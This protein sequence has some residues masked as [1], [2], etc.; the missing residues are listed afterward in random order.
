MHKNFW[1]V[2]FFFSANFIFSQNQIKDFTEK[3][4]LPNQVKE[5]SGLLFFN[6]KIITHNDS[7]DNSNLYELDSLTGN[8][9]R[10]V[11][12]TNATNIDWEDIAQDENHIYIGDF[13]NNNGN[14]INL[15]IYKILKSDFS[16]NTTV[17]AEKISFAYEDQTNFNN[18][19]NSHNFDAEALIVYNNQL[20]IFTKNRLDYRTNVYKLPTEPG[21]YAA[22]KVSTANVS[23]LITG[24]TTQNNHIMLCG[25]NSVGRPFLVYIN[26]QEKINDDIFF[27][28]FDKYVLTTE[29]EQGSQVEGITAYDDGKF[30]ISRE[31][32][33]IGSLK[34]PQK[35]YSF[36][37]DR[38]KIL[39]TEKN[40]VNKFSVF[41]N[42]TAGNLHIN[43]T[44]Q[45]R[46]ISL[47]NILGKKM[48]QIHPDKKLIDISHLSEG[49]YQLKVTYV[50][51]STLVKKIIKL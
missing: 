40:M 42:P 26:D 49:I 36:T 35:L 32:R 21:G 2:L 34:L 23:G 14:R 43:S 44:K 19:S 5:T 11:T 6:G 16:S 38:T 9:L 33:E 37:D 3:F 25:Y 4:E 13:G 28:G 45:I 1:L 7:G 27:N 48:M 50:D 12:I 46:S 15:K 51:T 22:V 47:Y 29:L 18:A 30:Y 39:S 10:T 20:L 24:A 8:L 17:T 31:K 41:P